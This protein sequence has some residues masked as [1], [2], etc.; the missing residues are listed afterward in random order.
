VGLPCCFVQ[1]ATPIPHLGSFHLR[2]FE[3]A[4]QGRWEVTEPVDSDGVHRLW[5]L[6]LFSTGARGMQLLP[7]KHFAAQPVA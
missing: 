2:R 3:T 6:A 5:S 1:V 4:K 7:L